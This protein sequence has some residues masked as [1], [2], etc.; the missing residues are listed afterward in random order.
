MDVILLDC[1][2]DTGRDRVLAALRGVARP[3]SVCDSW[4]SLQHGMG[5]QTIVIVVAPKLSRE[6][7][8][9]LR[10]IRVGRH[11][12]AGPVILVTDWERQNARH[13]KDVTV[14]D[15]IWLPDLERDLPTAI[16]RFMH[17]HQAARLQL[18]QEI[19]AA[20][21]IP[22]P[23]SHALARACTRDQPVDSI[24][25]LARDVGH[26][27]ST[28]GKQWRRLVGTERSERLKDFLDWLRLLDAAEARCAGRS[29]ESIALEHRMYRSALS[30]VVRRLTGCSLRELDAYPAL[31]PKLFHSLRATRILR[32]DRES[33]TSTDHSASLQA[34]S[35]LAGLRTES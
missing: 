30:R 33:P 26:S 31:V 24:L 18:A 12:T 3:A 17:R 28:I 2:A 16:C 19:E 8:A 32:G 10:A 14:D 34:R 5:R 1:E 9:R 7:L 11:G 4:D 6:R 23:L 22:W 20:S 27:R 29:W 13:L 21:W 15:V 35:V 25:T